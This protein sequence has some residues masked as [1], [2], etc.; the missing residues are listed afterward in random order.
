LGN[1]TALKST[2]EQLGLYGASV[3]RSTVGWVLWNDQTYED[4]NSKVVNH[5]QDPNGKYYAHSKGTFGF[6]AQTGF[7]LAHSTPGMFWR[8]LEGFGGFWR[9]WEGFGR[10]WTVLEGFRRF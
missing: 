4:I 10:F 1:A 7:W 2:I 9:V 8:V 6:D 3:D 5:E